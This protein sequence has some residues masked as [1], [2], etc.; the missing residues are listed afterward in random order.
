AAGNESTITDSLVVEAVL[1]AN[2]DLNNVNVLDSVLEDNLNGVTGYTF[3][4]LSTDVLSGVVDINIA[5][6]GFKFTVNGDT[7]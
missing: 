7:T 2:D 6:N 5:T 1:F 3:G 4:L